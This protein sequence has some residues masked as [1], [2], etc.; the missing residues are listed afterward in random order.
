MLY[1]TE[2]IGECPKTAKETIIEAVSTA[3]IASI[4]VSRLMNRAP[5]NTTY[6]WCEV[7]RIV[8]NYP[9]KKAPKIT[10]PERFRSLVR[11]DW[12]YT[13]LKKD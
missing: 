8:K 6:H 7:D 10:I 12:K 5:K 13:Q 3:M 4:L 2:L 11:V 9:F 1:I